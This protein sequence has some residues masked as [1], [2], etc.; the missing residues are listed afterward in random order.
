MKRITNL[1]GIIVGIILVSGSAWATTSVDSQWDGAGTFSVD[2]N[3]GD[4]SRTSLWTHGISVASGTFR[5]TDSNNNPYTY[6]VDSTESQVRASVVN[7]IIEYSFERT[8][9]KTS[10]GPAGQESYTFIDTFGTGNLDWRT[11]S[12]YASLSNSQYGFQ[13]NNQIRATGGHVIRHS[14]T[15]SMTEGA[16]IEVIADADTTITSMCETANGNSF[17][18]GRG[19]GCYTNAKVDIVG[20]GSFELNV[21][22]DNEIVTDTGITATGPGATY[23]VISNFGSGF[24]FDN[25][26]LRGN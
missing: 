23:K 5:A 14:L 24:Q 19:C 6:G 8:D 9:S 20:S 2:F 25:F 7:G 12:N 21:G 10:Y 26:A 3:A 22:A 13:A 18:F 17:T 15:N 4:D 1:L 16:G 11:Q